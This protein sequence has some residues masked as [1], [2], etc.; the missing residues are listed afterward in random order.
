MSNDASRPWL[1]L[2]QA[3]ARL[4][5]HPTTLRRWADEG[6]IP[7]LVTPGGH[8]RFVPADLE[9]FAEQHRRLRN[10]P[11]LEQAW[12]DLALAEARKGIRSHRGEH[13]LAAFDEG[14]RER[15]RQLGRRLLSLLLQ[16]VA[17]G[18]GGDDLLREAHQIGYAHGQNMLGLKMPLTEALQALFFF[19]DTLTES[20]LH[21]PE[22]AHVHQEANHRLL[23][24]LN[25]LL[26]AVQLGIA[27]A[28]DRESLHE[29]R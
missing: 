15:K 9:R 2:R 18:E 22:A 5:V 21:L 3:A 6:D 19:R 20:A 4:G 24:R 23:R 1:S 13:W 29:T 11:G 16:Y 28:Y 25:T 10:A 14:D 7:V 27:E 26:N 17:L 8:R 12:A